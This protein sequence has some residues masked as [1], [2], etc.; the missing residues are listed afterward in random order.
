MLLVLLVRGLTLPGAGA[1]IKFYLYPD[2]TRLEDPQVLRGWDTLSSLP[3]RAGPAQDR[4]GAEAAGST[5]S[6]VLWCTGLTGPL[7]PGTFPLGLWW[8]C[9]SPV[10]TDLSSC[11]RLFSCQGCLRLAT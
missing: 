8:V 10:L 7:P 1:G 5:S 3:P 9:L 4:A 2:I 6:V 11:V